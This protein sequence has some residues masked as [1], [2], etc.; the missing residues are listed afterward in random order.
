MKMLMLRSERSSRGQ[1]LDS[2]GDEW[3]DKFKASICRGNGGETGSDERW[4]VLPLGQKSNPIQAIPGT[5]GKGVKILKNSKTYKT[6]VKVN[7]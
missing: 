1:S 7:T 5:F 6:K 4:K 3:G 2:F